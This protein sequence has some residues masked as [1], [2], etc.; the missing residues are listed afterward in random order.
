MGCLL[1]I[2][3]LLAL[4]VIVSVLWAV[5]VAL[6]VLALILGVFAGIAWVID[7]CYSTTP[8]V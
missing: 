3:A 1:L 5:F 7:V 4:W 8:R 6:G 2:C